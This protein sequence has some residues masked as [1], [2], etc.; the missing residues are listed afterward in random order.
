M[1]TSA[2]EPLLLVGCG[3]L[4]KEIEF[5]SQKNRWALETLFADSMLHVDF[6]LLGKALHKMLAASINR[7]RL[8]FYGSCHPQMDDF[9][10]QAQLPR[11]P[12]QNCVEMLLGSETFM[13]DLERGAYFL[14]ED[15]ALRWE[16]MMH[17]LVG[18]NLNM[19]PAIF[20]ED[21]THILA[22]RTPC[23]DDFSAQA[24]IAARQTGLELRW[25]DQSLDILE[26]TL[27]DAMEK[28]AQQELT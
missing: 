27:R 16:V 9:L 8:V 3:I 17:K 28:V 24:E 6:H 20:Q 2:E 18:D 21:R 1:K 19:I 12:G 14:L 26:K 22:L 4:H 23:S 13:A 5:L 11:V 15:W 10:D 7:R 25:R